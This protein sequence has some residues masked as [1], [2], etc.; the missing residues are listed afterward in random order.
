[1]ERQKIAS[2]ERTD[3]V[4]VSARCDHSNRS[5]VQTNRISRR[6]SGHHFG[7]KKRPLPGCAAALFD[8]RITGRA[9]CRL[10]WDPCCSASDRSVA[11]CSVEEERPDGSE[12]EV[13]P[14]SPG[15]GTPA[16]VEA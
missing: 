11:A 14:A 10:F 8:L 16:F 6:H 9:S 15:A 2:T 7:N 3:R 1:M 4:S 13:V 12:E 5:S